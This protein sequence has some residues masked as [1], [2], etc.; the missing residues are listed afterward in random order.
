MNKVWICFSSCYRALLSR[1]KDVTVNSPDTEHKDI[2]LS[3]LLLNLVNTH[4]LFHY[5]S[6]LCVS[7]IICDDITSILHYRLPQIFAVFLTHIRAALSDSLTTQTVLS[8]LA[9]NS[10]EILPWKSS[11]QSAVCLR[12]WRQR[13][14][15]CIS[16]AISRSAADSTKGWDP[17][18]LLNLWGEKWQREIESDAGLWKE[19]KKE[20]TNKRLRKE[21]R[22][23]NRWGAKRCE[24]HKGRVTQ[25]EREEGWGER[26]LAQ[27]VRKRRKLLSAE[28]GR[29]GDGRIMAE[30]G[31]CLTSADLSGLRGKS[32]KE[33][34]SAP[35]LMWWEILP[36]AR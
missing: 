3:P 29:A 15:H 36:S 33:M 14:A 18:V 4:T 30:G 1:L 9:K 23:G 11:V 19:Q 2:K 10:P 24:N 26:K 25:E 35:I 32:L 8:S 7:W 17:W 13:R 22:L 16:V 28:R 31:A 21:R 34:G 6:L 12:V 27:R 5:S 20:E